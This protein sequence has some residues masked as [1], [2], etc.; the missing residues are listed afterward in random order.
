[1]AA[2][3][4]RLAF[5]LI[6][7]TGVG[8]SFGQADRASENQI[9]AA[10][11][12]QFGSFV[13]WPPRAFAGPD[14]PL[15]IGVIGADAIADE[16]EQVV[17]RRTVQARPVAVRKLQAGE[18]LTGLHVLFVGRAEAA[19]LGDIL[20]SAKEQALLV[21]TE[22]DDALSQ[23]SVINFVAVGNKVRFDVAL[24]QAERRQLKIS[25]RLLGVARRVVQG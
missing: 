12:Y 14:K 1:V 15:T 20:S 17:S 22:S 13:E 18:S 8:P 10:Y 6:L 21:V 25:S 23:G 4:L 19:Q 9:K 2:L 7:L 11:L 16:L 24:R 5:L 3:S